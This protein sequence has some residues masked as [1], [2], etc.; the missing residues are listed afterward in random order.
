MDAVD[1]VRFLFNAKDNNRRH[2]GDGVYVYMTANFQI[3]KF[4]CWFT[5]RFII[6][7]LFGQAPRTN[8][9]EQLMQMKKTHDFMIK[10]DS[11]KKIN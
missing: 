11:I 3:C 4:H 10:W 6:S 1:T 5:S 7:Y 8:D 9:L 2:P